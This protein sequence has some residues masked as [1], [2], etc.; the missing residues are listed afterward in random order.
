MPEFSTAIPNPTSKDLLDDH[1]LIRSIRFLIS[2]EQEA[3]SLYNQVIDSID[4]EDTIKV[5]QSI[6]DEEKVHVGE[7]C[8][9][10]KNHFA[11]NEE[12][13][14]LKGEEEVNEMFGEPEEYDMKSEE[15][16]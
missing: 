8:T 2:A 13:F 3:I 7:L 10:L 16:I 15:E 11:V 4:D 1:E 9:L 6:E 5:L 12:E 14:Y